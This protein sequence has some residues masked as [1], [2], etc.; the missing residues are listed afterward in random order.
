MGRGAHR[1]HAI[2]A[3]RVAHTLTQVRNHVNDTGCL[4]A[5]ITRRALRGDGIFAKWREVDGNPGRIIK[6]SIGF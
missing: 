4:C 3:R 1:E 5:E 6:F 2:P